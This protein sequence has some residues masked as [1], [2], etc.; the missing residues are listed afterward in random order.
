VPEP[1]AST[2]VADPYDIGD[3]NHDPNAVAYI[4]PEAT[5]AAGTPPVA[6]T[7]PAVP[8]TPEPVQARN[9]DGTFAPKA[10]AH[11]DWLMQQAA[12]LGMAE[13]EMAELPTSALTRQVSRLYRER[14][15]FAG[16]LA[17]ARTLADSTV[18]QP[19]PPQPPADDLGLT[20]EEE[21]EIAP[22][23][24]AT[25]KRQAKENRQLK[26]QLGQVVETQKKTQESAIDMQIDAGF[27]A[28]PAEY[29]A[30][31]GEGAM[32]DLTDQEAR[33]ARA[34]I[35]VRASR[36]QQGSWKARIAQAAKFIYG[37]VLKPAAPATPADPSAYAAAAAERPANGRITPE[38]W[39]AAGAA[40]P[41]Q[42]KEIDDEPPGEAKAI[43]NLS[44]KLAKLDGPDSDILDGIPD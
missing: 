31:I 33:E 22:S 24:L 10:P 36:I 3:P 41:T 2:P 40:R 18:R 38:A 25:L 43:K 16:E 12:E 44:A 29:K 30:V 35:Y 21:A 28:L 11:P 5:P 7:A 39:A 14:A 19:A 32:S 13:D 26:E 1:V 8:A 37:R 17:K 42:R 15:V 20:P 34:A 6:S 23:I 4:S 27:E 9:P